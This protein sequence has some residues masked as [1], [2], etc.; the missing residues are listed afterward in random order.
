MMWPLWQSFVSPMV[1]PS[2]VLRATSANSGVTTRSAGQTG[3]PS[4]A[5]VLRTVAQGA[6]VLAF[7]G[8]AHREPGGDYEP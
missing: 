8:C 4:L 3:S 2:A 7:S 6:R 5:A 1:H